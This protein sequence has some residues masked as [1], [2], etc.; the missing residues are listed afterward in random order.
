MKYELE[1]RFSI[2]R[3]NKATD[4]E[5]IAALRIYNETIPYEIR[6]ESNEITYW[7]S[8]NDNKNNNFELYIFILY[9]DDQMIGLSMTTYIKTIKVVIDEYLAVLEE[10]RINTI[11]LIYLSLIQSYY[12]ENNIGYSYYITEISNKNNGKNINRESQISLKV[13]CLEEF[14][15]INAP[16]YAL[17]L[18][19]DNHESNFEAYLY[20]K[21][22]DTI[23][24]ISKET[25]LQIVHAIYYDYSYVWYDKF[26]PRDELF[27]YK[28][29]VD[30]NYNLILQKINESNENELGIINQNCNITGSS[31]ADRT[32]GTIPVTKR[33]SYKLTTM[34]ILAVCILPVI[35][36]VGYSKVLAL[37]GIPVSETKTIIGSIISAIVTSLTTFYISKK[38]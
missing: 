18:G 13:L 14:G 8:V 11:F 38:K 6:T 32:S 33:T 17:P 25:Y 23:H 35:L 28:Q 12:A 37:F 4:E 19:L 1:H 36:I 20:L 2:R 15:K 31:N 29:E 22:N 21:T 30:R 9:L 26:L 10:Y 3:V 34:I 27:E 5:Y 16:Y 7:L 24:S